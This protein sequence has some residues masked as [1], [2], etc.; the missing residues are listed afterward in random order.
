MVQKYYLHD[1]QGRITAA[2]DCYDDGAYRE[3]LRAGG[4][5]FV[6]QFAGPALDGLRLDQLA[7]VDGAVVPRAVHEVQASSDTIKADGVATLTLTDAPACRVEILGPHAAAW[8]HAGGDI[9]LQFVLAG[10]YTITFDAFP[11]WVDP[12]QLEALPC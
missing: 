10:S 8:D 1:E 5:R 9:D 2:V 11:L 4:Y 7:V 6:E 12:V 3:T